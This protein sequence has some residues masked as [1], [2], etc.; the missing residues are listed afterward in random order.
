MLLDAAERA[1]Q[2]G[3]P[4][5]WAG[6][7]GAAG[8][9][10]PQQTA[11]AAAAVTQSSASADD[12]A[13]TITAAPVVAGECACA[14]ERPAALRSQ[15]AAAATGHAVAAAPLAV[16]TLES[17][18]SAPSWRGRCHDIAHAAATC[19]ARSATEAELC[20]AHGAEALE[21]VQTD[22][23]RTQVVSLMRQS[24][25]AAS[26][27]DIRAV[28]AAAAAGAACGA[29]SATPSVTAARAPCGGGAIAQPWAAHAVAG[30]SLQHTASA[31]GLGLDPYTGFV[32]ARGQDARTGAACCLRS[33]SDAAASLGPVPPQQV[34][35]GTTRVIL[36][37]TGS[38]ESSKY[39]G[40]S[41]I[42]LQVRVPLSRFGSYRPLRPT[43][44]RFKARS[45]SPRTGR[46]ASDQT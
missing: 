5:V 27:P 11:D 35:W 39:R 15:P 8:P 22:P 2:R 23:V 21:S 40:P 41:G 7:H 29:A 38:S 32:N 18:S 3:R 46:Y 4:P 12:A 42:L 36:L 9:C 31:S 26:L 34:A 10:R 20:A 33:L 17:A 28:I 25:F 37:G 16:M 44:M 6:T 43:C 13:I 45:V 30:A 1:L 19:Q 14:A 24:A